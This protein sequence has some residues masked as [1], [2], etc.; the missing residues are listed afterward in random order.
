M[1]NLNNLLQYN[2][3]WLYIIYYIIIIYVLITYTIS[4]FS[5]KA[6]MIGGRTKIGRGKATRVSAVSISAW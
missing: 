1:I 3:I 4:Y 2:K 5:K 6:I